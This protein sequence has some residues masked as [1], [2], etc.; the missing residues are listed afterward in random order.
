[1]KPMVYAH[2]VN[3]TEELLQQILSDARSLNNAAV[4]H[5]FTSSVVTRV[6]KC[7]QAY[8]GL[9]EQFA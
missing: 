1:M 2:K 3:M 5:K 9:F 8:G 7:I 6:R 4:L